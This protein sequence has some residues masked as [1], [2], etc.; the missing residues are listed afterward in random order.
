MPSQGDTRRERLA[1]ARLYLVTD[2]RGAE[3]DL[4]SFLDVVLAAGVD[5]VQLREK[6]AEAGDLLRSSKAFRAAADRYRALFVVNDRPD[7]AIAVGADGVHVGQNDLP[8]GVVRSIVGRD[9]IIG[10]STH[11]SMEYDAAAPD[12]DYL[13]VG[14][15]HSTP[16]KPG[17]PATGLE[18]VEHA[19]RRERD[20]SEPRPW[21][22]IGGIDDATL[23]EIVVVG[24]TRVTV[25]RAITNDPDP[26]SSVRGLVAGLRGRPIS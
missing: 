1:R 10:L 19:A 24:A 6:A 8:P 17:R 7:V 25:V 11:S 23:P 26:A 20:G 9:L 12:A 2:A 13:C 21:F 4:E 18:I 22:A 5:I 3:G 16:T 14:P 15:V